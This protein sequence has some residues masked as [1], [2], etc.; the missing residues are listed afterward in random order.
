MFPNVILYK[1][2]IL[3][4]Y[5]KERRVCSTHSSHVAGSMEP[6]PVFEGQEGNLHLIDC[7]DWDFFLGICISDFITRTKLSLGTGHFL[8]T[9]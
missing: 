7:I 2:H 1:L 8:D 3:D 6:I 9:L 5:T 4:S